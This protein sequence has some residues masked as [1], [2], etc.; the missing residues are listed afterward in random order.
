MV[1]LSFPHTISVISII[2]INANITIIITVIIN[3]FITTTNFPLNITNNNII[4]TTTL[5][6]FIVVVVILIPLR[7]SAHC[8]YHHGHNGVSS[9]TS[10]MIFFTLLFHVILLNFK[11]TKMILGFTI[12]I[13]FILFALI[14]EKLYTNLGFKLMHYISPLFIMVFY[15]SFFHFCQVFKI[16]WVISQTDSISTS[17]FPVFIIFFIH[18]V[19]TVK[20]I[21]S[22]M[23]NIPH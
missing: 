4:I 14:C 22:Q 8:N 13:I 6:H 3:H 15:F 1:T 5:K 10:L 20:K 16:A 23:L 2:N 11:S 9:Q 18:K 17:K 12:F 19:S 21:D 7:K